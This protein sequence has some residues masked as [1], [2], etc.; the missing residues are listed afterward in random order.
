M[1]S[2]GRKLQQI[3]QTLWEFRREWQLQASVIKQPPIQNQERPPK[4]LDRRTKNRLAVRIIPSLF[5]QEEYH[6]FHNIFTIHQ[7]TDIK[8]FFYQPYFLI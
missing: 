6:K 1:A 7:D 3:Y 8:D 2:P 4:P 5:K